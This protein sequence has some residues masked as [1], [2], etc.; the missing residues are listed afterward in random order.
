MTAAENV[1]SPLAA[2]GG[3]GSGSNGTGVVAAPDPQPGPGSGAPGTLQG[4]GRDADGSPSGPCASRSA[5]GAVATSD[6]AVVV[7]AG[8]HMG[9]STAPAATPDPPDP[10]Q[11]ATS[12]KATARWP[13]KDSWQGGP[14]PAE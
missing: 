5:D 4:R 7:S 2:K 3:G 13:P 8:V 10:T 6:C 9:S 12:V 14:D 11:V 1:V